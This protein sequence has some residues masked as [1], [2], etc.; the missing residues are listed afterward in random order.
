MPRKC[1][2]WMLVAMVDS[3]IDGHFNERE[4][5]KYS[6]MEASSLLRDMTPTNMIT[7]K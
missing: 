6:S 5:M 1:P 2:A 4:L 3:A 7:A